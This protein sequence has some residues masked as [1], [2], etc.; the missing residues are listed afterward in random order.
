MTFVLFFCFFQLPT[1]VGW[2]V[3]S[4]YCYTNFLESVNNTFMFNPLEPYF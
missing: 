3:I 4:K 1:Q 2:G